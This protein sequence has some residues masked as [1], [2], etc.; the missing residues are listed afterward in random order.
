MKIYIRMLVIISAL[1][2]SITAHYSYANDFLDIT[3]PPK[4]NK[5]LL[6]ANA[7][8]DDSYLDEED[9]N[10]EDEEIEKIYDP[11]EP[12][13]RLFFHFNDKLYFWFL[14]PVATGYSKVVPETGRI[15]VRNFFDN[16]TTPVRLVNN[17][18]QFKFDSAG[19]ELKRFCINTTVGVLGFYDFAK[20]KAG[21]KMQEED[22]GQT[23]GVWFDA[24]PGFY[25]VWPV[26]GPSSLRDSAGM[27]GDFYLDPVSYV[28]PWMYDRLAIQSG[29][30]INRVS[31]VLGDYEDIKKDALDPYAAFRD[32]YHQYREK[33]IDK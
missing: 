2:F 13:N 17:V 32:I 15:Y 3:P 27:A 1:I 25:I 29:D 16:I 8:E 6:M 9:E 18:L 20:N 24:G 19:T 21:I 23:L 10:G 26:L 11:I 4:E 22:L 28:T 12:V 33:K 30:K 5:G 31:L 14:K 7:D